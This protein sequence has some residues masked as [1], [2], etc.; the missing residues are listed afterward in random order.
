MILR[1]L[2]G[3]EADDARC[4]EF[5]LVDFDAEIIV[6]QAD[7]HEFD[8]SSAVGQHVY[9]E[10]D[11]SELLDA[12]VKDADEAYNLYNNYAYRFGFSIRKGKTRPRNDGTVCAR[13][14]VCSK[15]G[16]KKQSLPKRYT[17]T[18]FRTGCKAHV[19][20]AVDKSGVHRCKRHVM[21]HN[22]KLVDV[23]KR[24]WL[25]SQRNVSKDQLDMFTSWKDNGMGVSDAYRFVRKESGGFQSV[26]CVI[27]DVYN[28]V[29]KE[30][31]KKI[32]G[33]DT[34]QLLKMFAERQTK[35]TDF[36]YDLELDEKGHIISFFWRDGIMKRDYE[37]FSDLLVFDTTYRTNKYAMICAPFVGMNHHNKNVMFGVGFLLNEKHDSFI[38]LYNTFL[39]SMGQI[40]PINIM[41]DQCQSMAKAISVAFPNSCHRLCTWHI[42][43]NATKNIPHLKA[44]KGFNSIFNYVLKYTN[45]EAEFEHY[46]AR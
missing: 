3:I 19:L 14:F 41:T 24:H 2:L 8:S 22:H 26:G 25:R 46:W 13:E 4:T 27:K 11:T 42:G 40:Q 6:E 23:D 33:C 7:D 12:E 32:K 38:W 20:F 30:K 45:I 15:E 35:E 10:A 34:K 36:Y 43:K 39:R 16:F 37:T 1:N 31:R 29:G 28:A 9:S 21:D 5:A 44:L 18:D 17:K